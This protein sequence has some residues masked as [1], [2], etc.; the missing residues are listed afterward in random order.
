[1]DCSKFQYL[2]QEASTSSYTWTTHHIFKYL[3][4]LGFNFHINI[5]VF[6]SYLQ[7]KVL[8]RQNRLYFF[9]I[10]SHSTLYNHLLYIL[11][12]LFCYSIENRI[13]NPF[14]I[15]LLNW[16]ISPFWMKFPNSSPSWIFFM[17]ISEHNYVIQFLKSNRLIF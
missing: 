16:T 11:W 8:F 15:C 6:C 10:N 7:F 14:H 13:L 9:F 12:L 5:I 1:M 17:S 2:S 3:S 4:I